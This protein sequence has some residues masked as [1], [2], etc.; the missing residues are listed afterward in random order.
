MVSVASPHETCW[1]AEY[2]S[3]DTLPSR[4]GSSL[5]SFQ[6][7]E[8]T[9]RT[10]HHERPHSP[11]QS[12]FIDHQPPIHHRPPS[13]CLNTFSKATAVPASPLDPIYLKVAHNASII[14][15]RIPRDILFSDLK[16]RLYEKFLNQEN[17]RLSES[18]SVIL[19]VPPADPV[20][21]AH[22]YSRRAPVAT[23]TEMRFIDCEAD[24][25]SI[26]TKNDGSKITLRVLDTPLWDP[27]LIPFP[28]PIRLISQTIRYFTPFS[29]KSARNALQTL[30]D[31]AL[32]LES[33]GDRDYSL[34]YD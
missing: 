22:L 4:P 2:S 23:C 18:F 3:T 21:I 14:M 19:A 8:P 28:R 12:S 17:I 1:V 24:W 6:V 9:I 25:R 13:A 15:L 20:E 26:T 33:V 11:Q 7:I 31:V 30:S 34:H 32:K 10:H 29:I 16:R 27:Q 5:E